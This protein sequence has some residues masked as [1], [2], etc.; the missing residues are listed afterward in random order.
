VRPFIVKIQV[1]LNQHYVKEALR[2]GVGIKKPTKKQ[3]EKAKRVIKNHLENFD[4]VDPETAN[5]YGI[6]GIPDDVLET[7][8]KAFSKE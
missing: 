1:E 6:Y 2:Y 3:L 7:I 5:L 8:G 4:A